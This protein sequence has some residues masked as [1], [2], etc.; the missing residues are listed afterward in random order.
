MAT[1]PPSSD[2][3]PDSASLSAPPTDRAM[4]DAI[5]FD[6][7][8]FRYG[9][10][11]GPA[12]WVLQ[13]FTLRVA[14]GEFHV[15]LGPSGCGKTTVLKLVA[16]FEHAPRGEVRAGGGRLVTGPGRD[17]V[18]LFQG[19]DS[20]YPWLTAVENVE[21]GL[22][23]AGT[24]RLERRER[25]LDCLRL[26]G[27]KGHDAKFPGQLSG[28][29]K[30]RV[31]L[32][33][34]LVTQPTTLLMD[35]PFGALDAQTRGALQG[36]VA[37]IWHH[38]RCT[39]MFITHDITEAILLADR[40]S[41]MTPGPAAS[42]REIIDLNLPRPRTVSDPSFGAIYARLSRLLVDRAPPHDIPS[43]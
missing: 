11:S 12:E 38:T 43:P 26:V 39:V 10:A 20:L 30:Q 32:A 3:G 21:F 42:I 24:P 33:R 19:D 8:S 15:I 17:R 34:A 18:M 25:A 22:R 41:V 6:H 2:R 29:M 7:V 5:S 28:G 14:R 1:P 23:V 37:K 40:V 16:G 9:P 31:Q 27:L 35:E 36:E 4:V 13:G